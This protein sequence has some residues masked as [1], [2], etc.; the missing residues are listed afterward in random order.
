M[1]DEGWTSVQMGGC[2]E[3]ALINNDETTWPY[4]TD[5]EVT[6]PH[7][8]DAK[9]IRPYFND[10]TGDLSQSLNAFKSDLG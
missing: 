3:V 4:W 1:S 9:A 8:A 6:W 2:L 10:V 7:Q 5:G